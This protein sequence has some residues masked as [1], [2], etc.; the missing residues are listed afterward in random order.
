MHSR[1]WGNEGFMA[2]KLNMNKVYDMVELRFLEVMMQKM[3]FEDKW[4]LD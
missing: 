2:V 1:M 3:G 4:H